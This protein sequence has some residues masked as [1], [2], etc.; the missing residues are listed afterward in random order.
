MYR[1]ARC[2]TGPEPA[3]S[4]RL[5]LLPDAWYQPWHG[6]DPGI[7]PVARPCLTVAARWCGCTATAH[8]AACADRDFVCPAVVVPSGSTTRAAS[9]CMPGMAGSC[10]SSCRR[11]SASSL[12]HLLCLSD[13]TAG[14]R[15]SSQ[16][17]VLEH[18]I[19]CVDRVM[20]LGGFSKCTLLQHL[21]HA[22]TCM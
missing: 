10:T 7:A 22:A 14:S 12:V 3:A 2:C 9:G 13:H 20:F 6:I 18:G 11:R 8:P 19:S 17:C 4:H 5:F 15:E 16:M 21:P 1:G